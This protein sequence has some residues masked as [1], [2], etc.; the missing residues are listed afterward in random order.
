MRVWK[1][2]LIGL[3]FGVLL[4]SCQA[5]LAEVG[6]PVVVPG[7]SLEMAPIPAGNFTM[8]SPDHESGRNADEGPQ[9]VVTL[10]KYFW[11]GKYEVTQQQWQSLMGSNPSGFPGDGNL[12]VEN[13]TWADAAAFG[14]KLT[15]QER[16]AGRLPAGYVYRLPTEAEWEYACRAGT[17][18]RFYTGD[19]DS[20][21]DAAAWYK[22]NSDGKTHPV[23]QKKPNAWGLY[24]MNG[25]VWEWCNDWYASYAKA[26][27]V[28]PQGPA[29][30]HF[31]V[32]RG[33][34]WMRGV[35]SSR[36][37]ER[38][39]HHP[40]FKRSNVGFRIA[41]APELAKAG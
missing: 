21:L 38:D 8:G 7:L 19:K 17:T 6:M 18:T 35:A 26:A 36:S 20:D 9:R 25:N 5:L 14:E 4:G 30:G 16:A 33:G 24:D 27:I 12:P 10:T 15:A 28:D 22:N 23:G 11:L 13:I 41:L 31:H 37:A 3:Y 32:A 29:E 2:Q 39:H 40:S 1:S 34:G